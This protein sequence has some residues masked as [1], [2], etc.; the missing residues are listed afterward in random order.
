MQLK[1]HVKGEVEGKK[2]LIGVQQ[3]RRQCINLWRL[4][5]VHTDLV[6]VLV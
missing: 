2:L 5:Y 6:L 4:Q 1:Q 3:K